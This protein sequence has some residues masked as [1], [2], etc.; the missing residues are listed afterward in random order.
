VAGYPVQQ[1]GTSAAR[2]LMKKP[3]STGTGVMSVNVRSMFR[4][5]RAALPILIE[6]AAQKGRART[7]CRTPLSVMALDTDIGLSAY[8]SSKHAV[9]GL[10]K[11][12]ALEYG[13]IT[14]NYILP[15]AIL[16][17]MTRA[18][19]EQPDIAAVWAKKS[20]L[21]RLRADG[22]RPRSAAAGQRRGRLHHRPRTGGR[23]WSR[24][25]S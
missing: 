5:C 24:L 12:L 8:T 20:A 22:H 23:W 6:R 1:R 25:R 14:A 21:R 3:T 18:T 2:W 10:T 19:L 9:A 15:G 13:K 4:I 16:T 17:G 7:S 11:T